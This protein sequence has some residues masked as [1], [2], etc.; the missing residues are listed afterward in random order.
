MRDGRAWRRS[1]D[2]ER[3]GRHLGCSLLGM[4][5]M[6]FGGCEHY[7]AYLLRVANKVVARW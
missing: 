7:N 4:A 6:W 5:R 1:L 3:Q 2:A